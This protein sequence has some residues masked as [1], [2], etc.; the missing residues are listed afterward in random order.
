MSLMDLKLGRYLGIKQC[1]QKQYMHL[2]IQL[3]KVCFRFLHHLIDPVT[4]LRFQSQ[5]NYLVNLFISHSSILAKSSYKASRKFIFLNFINYLINIYFNPN[6]TSKRKKKAQISQQNKKKI[7]KFCK[8]FNVSSV[9]IQHLKEKNAK[10]VF[11]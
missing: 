2:L 9:Q 6:T 10:T 8:L 11:F 3:N 1:Y 7:L 5:E 4:I